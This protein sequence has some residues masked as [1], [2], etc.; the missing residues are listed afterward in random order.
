[1][2]DPQTIAHPYAK[3]A[4][5]FAKEQQTLE[6]WAQM[7]TIV[8]DV[9]TQPVISEQLEDLE[10]LGNEQREQFVDMLLAIC[11]G[12]LDEHVKNLIRVMAENSRLAVL[13]SV[14][15]L[16]LELK[17]DYERTV[18][19]HVVSADELTADQKVNLIAALEKKLDRHVELDC[20]ID[21][22]LVGGM[23]IHAGEL[24][25]DGTLK[26]SMDRLASRLQA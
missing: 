19:A 25:I 6:Q 17:A 16:F 7:L 14:T 26:T 13:S 12:L 21:K 18:Q 4:F 23:L 22:S 15:E 10:Q 11:D 9:V 2:S 24:V 20:Q 3:A 1:M 8:S 5:E